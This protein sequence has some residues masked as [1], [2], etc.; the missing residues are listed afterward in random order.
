MHY[1][2]G[3]FFHIGSIIISYKL[4]QCRRNRSIVLRKRYQG[5][6]SEMAHFY[7]YSARAVCTSEKYEHGSIPSADLFVFYFDTDLLNGLFKNL[8]LPGNIIAIIQQVKVNSLRMCVFL[9]INMINLRLFQ[10]VVSWNVFRCS[11]F[12]MLIVMDIGC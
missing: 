12:F 8:V 4:K 9:V 6:L 2:V 3:L 1:L 11:Y 10:N 7:E 5:I